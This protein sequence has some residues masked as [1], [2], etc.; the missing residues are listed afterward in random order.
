[1]PLTRDEKIDFGV[2][3]ASVAA[4][5]LGYRRL[6]GGLAV[7]NGVYDLTK[8]RKIAGGAN[9]A[10]GGSFLLFPSW[11]ESLGD[12][13]KGSGQ[14]ASAAKQLPPPVQ[15]NVLPFERISFPSL[16]RMLDGDWRML[17]VR[18]IRSKDVAAKAQNLKAGD[19]ASLVLQNKSG[20]FMVFNA[21]VI[22]GS[23][24]TMYAG[25]WASQPPVGGPQMIDW[26]PEHV[27]ATH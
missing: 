8:D 20:P 3:V 25:Q 14:T 10:V 27:F 1:M 19:T 4:F 18:D 21:K 23:A 9:L 13:I 22:G 24:G 6:A 5:V 26:S 16:D 2:A 11:P 15:L 12:A 17:D 7:A